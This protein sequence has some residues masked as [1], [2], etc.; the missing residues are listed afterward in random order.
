MI[1]NDKKPAK[2]NKT[3]SLDQDNWELVVE[4]EI[5]N[6]SKFINELVNDALVDTN[7]QKRILL[8]RVTQLQKDARNLGIELEIN[9]KRD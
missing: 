1:W 9:L 3:V 8:S 2:I 7:V 6:F 4:A 5:P